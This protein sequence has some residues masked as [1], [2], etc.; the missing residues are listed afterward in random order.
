[1]LKKHSIKHDQEACRWR[2]AVT[3]EHPRNPFSILH[4]Y[5]SLL[6]GAIRNTAA[7]SNLVTKNKH[8]IWKMLWSLQHMLLII[9]ATIC[10]KYSSYILHFQ[11]FFFFCGSLLDQKTRNPIITS[12]WIAWRKFKCVPVRLLGSEENDLSV[13]GTGRL[14]SMKIT[15]SY[16]KWTQIDN[17]EKGPAEWHTGVIFRGISL[18]GRRSPLAREH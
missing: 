9:R 13:V 15:W 8:I 7:V 17:I 14:L 1:M 5:V 3:I 6:C 4:N 11:M 2:E 18:W 12:N 10:R 16:F